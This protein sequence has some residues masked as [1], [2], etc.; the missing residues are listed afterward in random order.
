MT[1]LRGIDDT[2]LI[3][4]TLLERRGKNHQALNDELGNYR[5]LRTSPLTEVPFVCCPTCR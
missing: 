5:I 3:A 2:L 4:S 1:V